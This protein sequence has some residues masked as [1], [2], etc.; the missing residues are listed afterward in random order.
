M[1][2]EFDYIVV[3]AGSAGGLLAEKLSRN[4][5]H[6]VLLLEGGGTHKRF[7]ITMPA[8]WGKM[9]YDKNFSWGN[10]TEPEEW[11]GGRRLKLPRGKALGGSSSINGLLYVRGHKLDYQD[12]VDAGA[13]GWSWDDLMP[14]FKATEDQHIINN[15]L[16]VVVNIIN[17]DQLTMDV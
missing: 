13:T 15:S 14:H 7:L 4:G 16:H 9:L 5:K 8:G 12:W 6:T 1:S 3:G 2:Q 10:E 11:A 17:R